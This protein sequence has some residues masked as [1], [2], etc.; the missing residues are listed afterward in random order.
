MSELARPYRAV[1]GAA[2]IVILVAISVVVVKVAYGAWSSQYALTGYFVRAGQGLAPSSQV[3]YRGVTVGQVTAISLV[4][5]RAMVEMKID[6]SFKIPTDAVATIAP[7]NVFGEESVNLTFPHGQVGPAIPPGG[8][9][10]D[11]AVSDNFTQLFAAADPLLNEID[12]GSLATVISQLAIGTAGLGPAIRASIDEG[13][14]LADLFDQTLQSQIKALDSFAAF[15]AAVGP[16]GPSINSISASEN[17]ALPVLNAEA[18]E[19]QRLLADFTPLADE[20][21]A[22]LSDYHPDITTM[23]ADGANVS[24]VLIAD[25]ANVAQVIQGLASYVTRIAD[26][27]GPEILPD[28]TKFAYFQT[29]VLFSDV[30]DL[31]CSLIAPA[32]PGL[33]SLEPLQQALTGAGSPFDCSA[34]MAAFDKAQGTSAPAHPAS[35]ANPANP[36]AAAKNAAQGLSNTIGSIIGQ[37]DHTEPQSLGG[38]LRQLLGPTGP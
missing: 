3:Q 32:T 8:T 23:L 1:I 20:L 24:R 2:V 12:T 4:D 14:Q 5:R 6:H 33:S 17:Q 10:R 19:Y 9:I 18:A 25:Q 34:Q 16:T 13:T 37:P 11:T 15:S 7:I 22:Y 35:P 21:A 27:A 31:V 36:L 28:G 30:N 26:G 29:F 38:V